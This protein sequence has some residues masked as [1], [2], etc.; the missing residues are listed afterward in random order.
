MSC[1]FF[2]VLALVGV[3]GGGYWLYYPQYRLTHRSRGWSHSC[4]K[5]LMFAL[6]QRARRPRPCLSCREAQAPEASLSLLYPKYADEYVLQGKTVPLDL[7][8]K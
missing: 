4:D 5:I 2:I 8:K 7:V 3:A 6:N 1:S